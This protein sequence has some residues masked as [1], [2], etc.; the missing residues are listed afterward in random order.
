MDLTTTKIKNTYFDNRL[1][2]PFP[3]HFIR[4]IENCVDDVHK[5]C[6]EICTLNEI[7]NNSIIYVIDSLYKIYV[8]DV[9]ETLSKSKLDTQNYTRNYTRNCL[10]EFNDTIKKYESSI[11]FNNKQLKITF[12]PISEY[13]LPQEIS[14][15]IYDFNNSMK[16]MFKIFINKNS[17]VNNNTLDLRSMISTN[18]TEKTAAY[19]QLVKKPNDNN[20][21]NFNFNIYLKIPKSFN[22]YNG[23]KNK[24][25]Q[26]VP[27]GQY[28]HAT[29]HISKGFYYGE[30]AGYNNG[31]FKL[32]FRNLLSTMEI[33][34]DI[35]DTDPPPRNWFGGKKSRR[36]RRRR[37]RKTSSRRK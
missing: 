23:K 18:N 19:I 16:L 1:Q 17:V 20:D 28:D 21:I 29:L 5:S 25:V 14:D 10:V 3:T 34:T 32:D 15:I 27:M 36:C 26:L 30:T 37:R 2:P 7:I 31:F 11:M 6:D 22:I 24:F 4:H 8:T 13:G 35:D 12:I 33:A 9:Y